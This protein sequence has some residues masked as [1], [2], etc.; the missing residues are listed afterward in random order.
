VATLHKGGLKRVKAFDGTIEKNGERHT[1]IGVLIEEEDVRALF[2]GLF[3]RIQKKQKE[4]QHSLKE[5]QAKTEK[6]S[7]R[8]EKLE[9]ALIQD[10]VPD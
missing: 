6:V 1:D 7:S 9:E 8:L 5:A 2:N 4:L 3:M 10:L